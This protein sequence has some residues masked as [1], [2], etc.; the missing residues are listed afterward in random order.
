MVGEPLDLLLQISGVN[1]F[2]SAD[3]AGVQGPAAFLEQRAV[4]HL[5]GEGVLEGVLLLGEHLRL[6]QELGRLQVGQAAMEI[7]PFRDSHG[8]QQRARHV[9]A[10]HRGDLQQAL[11]LR[12]QT[13]D[14]GGQHRLHRGRHPDA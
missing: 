14:A 9:L 3:D 13:I 11:L 7:Q 5:V 1:L 2:E 12:R 10:D 8:L 4:G 6:V